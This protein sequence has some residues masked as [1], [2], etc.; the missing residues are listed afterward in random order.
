MQNIIQELICNNQSNVV[1]SG[2]PGKGI[3]L[4]P[5]FHGTMVGEKPS[6]RERLDGSTYIPHKEK[7]YVARRIPGDRP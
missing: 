6:P 2:T 3:S 5:N 1:I 4:P 7:G